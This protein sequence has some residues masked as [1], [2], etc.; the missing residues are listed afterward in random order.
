MPSLRL[1]LREEDHVADAFLAEEHHAEA[2][3]AEAEAA[4]RGA[5]VF[6]GDE[7]IWL[8]LLAAGLVLQRVALRALGLS[9]KRF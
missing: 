2:V 5:S 3:E 9:A 4:R 8:L 6:E 7:E 1:Q